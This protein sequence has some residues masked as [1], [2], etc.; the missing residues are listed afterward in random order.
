MVD[1]LPLQRV[2]ESRAPR[3]SVV[4]GNAVLGLWLSFK[5]WQPV[6][7]PDVAS[8]V[9]HRANAPPSATASPSAAPLVLPLVVPET[10]ALEGIVYP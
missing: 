5:G 9:L 8:S 7:L 10:A 3:G 2:L 4:E 6:L 1:L